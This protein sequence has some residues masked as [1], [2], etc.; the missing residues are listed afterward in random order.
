MT[1]EQKLASGIVEKIGTND[2]T[3]FHHKAGSEPV[4]EVKLAL[5]YATAMEKVAQVIVD[6]FHGVL[7][8][9]DELEAVGHRVVHGGDR[10]LKPVRI[11]ESVIQEL[12]ALFPLAPLH[13]PPNVEGIRWAK[14]YFPQAVQVAVFDTS[15]YQQM[16]KYAHLYGLPRQV[17]QQYGIRK[18]GF[19]GISH[20]YVAEQAARFLG[21]GLSELKLITCHIGN[22]VSITATADGTP[23]DTSMGFTPLEGVMM[24]TRSG[25]LDP[26]IIP[27][28]KEK[29]GKS[30]AQVIE[31]L[32][33]ESGLLGV[34]GISHD[35]RELIAAMESGEQN[36]KLAIDI[37]VYQMQK[38][39]GSFLP[40]LRG[41]DVLVFT[42]GVGE[43]VPLIRKR[44]C[45]AFRFLGVAISDEANQSAQSGIHRISTSSSKVEVLVV[46]TNEEWMIATQTKALAEGRKT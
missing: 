38:M 31:M 8:D 29:T 14:D 5:D 45:E 28:L 36:A 6:P 27:F 13:N 18:Y 44:I 7:K 9:Y 26:A 20:A 34:S 22:G 19:H 12:I 3:F 35:L 17:S 40:V 33:H 39:I 25:S 37:Y 43:N 42:A 2:A 30:A 21:K 16:P 15:F 46:P 11:D 41:L 10:F 32:N 24:G 23:L 1:Q 4:T